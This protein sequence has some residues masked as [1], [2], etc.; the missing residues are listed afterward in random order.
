M[1]GLGTIINTAAIIVG[2]FLGLMF[3]KLINEKI[4]DSLCK[5]GLAR[6]NVGH[7]TDVP[8]S[9]QGIFSS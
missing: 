4:K 9:L 2:G 5:S 6:I 3:G 8:G 7:N 1:P